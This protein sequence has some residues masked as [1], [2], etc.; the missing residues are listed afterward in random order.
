[1][2]R[3]SLVFQRN[4]NLSTL[5]AT[6]TAIRVFSSLEATDK[7]L[8]KQTQ[9]DDHVVITDQTIFHAQGGGQPSD[10]GTMEADSAA[11]FDVHMVRMAA[12][13]P[14]QVLHFGQFAD[15]SKSFQ[16]GQ[17]VTQ[18]I[19]SEK[20]RLYSRYHSAGHVLGASVRALLE[21]QIEGFDEI[22]ASHFPD[23]ASCE[24]MGLIEGKWKDDIQK[25]LDSYIEKDMPIEIDWWDEDDFKTNG[26]ERLTPDRKAM[27]MEDGEKFRVVKIVG[28]ETYPCGG[29]HVE[30]TKSCGKTTVKKISRSKGTSRVSY[31]L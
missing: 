14:N 2:Q 13:N 6:V 21:K 10:E 25:L 27:N 17:Q 30:S 7:A 5:Q 19:D 29:T 1:M 22:K 11:K 26:L 8:S 24:F 15:P 12:T 9:E 3:T 31:L 4:G 18:T 20:R 16:P 23:S 28:A